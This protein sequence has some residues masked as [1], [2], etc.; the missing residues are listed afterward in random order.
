MM[1]YDKG[2]MGCSVV[3]EAKMQIRLGTGDDTEWNSGTA[4]VLGQC[5]C[6]GKHEHV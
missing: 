2:H 4:L 5:S 1:L 3:A 6:V